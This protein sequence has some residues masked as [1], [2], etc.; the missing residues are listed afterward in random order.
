M[1]NSSPVTLITALVYVLSGVTQPLLVTIAKEAGIADPKC[2]LYML[3]YYIGPACVIFKMDWQWWYNSARNDKMSPWK[4]ILKITGIALVDITAQSLNYTGSAMA[5]PTIFAIIY[6]SV[7]VW[8]ALLSRLCLGRSMT[9]DQ[10]IAVVIVFVGLVVAGCSSI[11]LGEEVLL[12]A[13]IVLVGS[14]LH[15][16][17]YVLSEGIMN[18][19]KHGGAVSVSSRDYCAIFALVGTIAFFCWQMVYTRYHFE[20]LVLTPMTKSGT[21]YREAIFILLAIAI[22]NLVHGLTFFHTVKHFPGGATSAGI[23][24]GLQAVLIFVVTGLIFCHH[25]GG[26]EMCYTTAKFVSLI[27][28]VGGVF[29]FG[30]ATEVLTY[31]DR[32]EHYESLS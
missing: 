13:A 25:V 27:I 14:A 26:Q 7:T 24:K 30:K 6:S 3:F 15:A 20:D 23:M 31:G 17:M 4:I 16:L 1:T 12:G 29:Y 11:S 10:W 32:G 9:N 18:N 5:G 8:C 22:M 28:V 19:D 21:S 2:L